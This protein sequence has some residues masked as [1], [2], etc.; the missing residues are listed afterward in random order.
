MEEIPVRKAE[1]QGVKFT[2]RMYK[3]LAAR[4][5][6]EKEPPMPKPATAASGG[7]L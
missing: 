2:E 3:N 5:R 6:F 7:D 1:N 4:D